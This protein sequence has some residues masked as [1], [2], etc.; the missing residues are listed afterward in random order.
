MLENCINYPI[1]IANIKNITG[2]F[3]NLLEFLSRAVLWARSGFEQIFAD[4]RFSNFFLINWIFFGLSGKVGFVGVFITV[5]EGLL[6]IITLEMLE[7]PGLLAPLSS[8]LLSPLSSKLLTSLS[9]R[10]LAS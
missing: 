8:E 7:R 10:L 1:C 6:V 5:D 9:S 4:F 2:L 3:F